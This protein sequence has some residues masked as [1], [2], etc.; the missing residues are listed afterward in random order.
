MLSKF[1][2]QNVCTSFGDWVKVFDAIIATL[3]IFPDNRF[4]HIKLNTIS[5]RKSL[6]FVCLDLLLHSLIKF[7]KLLILR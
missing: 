7:L 1:W 2:S 3:L 6:T 5:H 4:I